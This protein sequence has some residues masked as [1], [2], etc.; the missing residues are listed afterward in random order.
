MAFSEGG[1]KIP[2]ANKMAIPSNAVTATLSTCDVAAKVVGS[3]REGRQ[4]SFQIF[5]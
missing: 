2:K 4:E 3:S 5:Y 1:T